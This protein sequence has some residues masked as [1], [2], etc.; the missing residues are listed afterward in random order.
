MKIDSVVLAAR[1]NTCKLA[2][3]SDEPLEAN[4][5]ISGKPMLSYVLSI[6]ERSPDISRIIVVGPKD[7]L[8]GYEGGKVCIVEPGAELIDNVRIGLEHAKTESVLVA[9]SDIPLLTTEALEDFLKA[10]M[11]SGA[12]FV[13]SISTKEDCISKFPGAERTYV[14]VKGQTFTGGNLF[15]VRRSIVDSA[16]PVLEKMIEYRK[17]PLKMASFFGFGFVARVFLGFAGVPEIEE[18]VSNLLGIK[19]KAVISAP[20][21]S[22]DVDKP[23]DLELA[24]GILGKRYNTVG[25][26]CMVLEHKISVVILAAGEG[27]RMKSSTPKVLFPICGRP[28]VDYVLDAASSVKPEAIVVVVGYQGEEVANRISEGWAKGSP[29]SGKI[30]FAWQHERRGTG[31]AVACALEQIPGCN[32]VMI[33]YG[34]T[35]LITGDM[36]SRFVQSHLAR[37]ADLSLVTAVVDDPGEYGRIRRDEKGSMVGIVEAKDLLPG[38]RH[39]K[40]INAGI[41]IV[42]KRILAQLISKFDDNNAKRE[43]YLTDIVEKAAQAG[44]VVS[45]F[46]C[47]DISLVEGV[48]DRYALSLAESRL[49]QGVLRKLCLEGVTIRDPRNTYV[50]PG[51]TI[52]PDTV[53]EP[54]TFLRGKTSIG[55]GCVIGPN[56]EVIDSQVG[57]KTSI[58]FSVVEESTIGENVAIGPFSHLRPNSIIEDHVSI[59]NF[60]EVKNSRIGRGTKVHHHSYLGDCQIGCQVNIGAGTVTV[61]YDGHKKH[62]TIVEDNAFIGCNANLI[63]PVRIG[64]DSYVAA[65][66][67]ITQDVPDGALGIAR[68]RQANKEGW[69]AKRKQKLD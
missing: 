40:E 25:E 63:A 14:K 33:L 56:T 53:I 30:R 45:S 15:F 67:T 17:A 11:D 61:N 24:R 23:Q 27:T 55:R 18:Y 47:D 6:L 8:A 9:S 2:S 35:P 19:C 59:G 38:D 48:N 7:G 28:M 5:D 39:I 12:D 26:I 57:D 51:V 54:G 34:D 16:W 44:Y 66:S 4:I 36:L 60:A 52:G 22:V 21:I 37:K 10:A 42:G 31:H 20:E 13:Y 69:V 65:G 46:V 68:E 32:D 58:R 50:D 49:R 41:Y 29:M 43:F 64:K 62:K 3:V 1:A